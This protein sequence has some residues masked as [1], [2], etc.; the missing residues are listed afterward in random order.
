MKNRPAGGHG[1]ETYLHP[2]NMRNHKVL[3]KNLPEGT[4][5][6]IQSEAS[7]RSEAG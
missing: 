3:Y 4:E 7:F 2:I 5:G 6:N 1:S